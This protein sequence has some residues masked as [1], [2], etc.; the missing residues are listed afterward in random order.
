MTHGEAT[1]AL[2][3]GLRQRPDAAQPKARAKG[4]ALPVAEADGPPRRNGARREKDLKHEN[5]VGNK[6][7]K[8]HN[9]QPERRPR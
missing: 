5:G 1:A 6:R 2:R 4:A 8:K 3:K 7:M 9:S